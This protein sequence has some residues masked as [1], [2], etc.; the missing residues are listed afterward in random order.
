[1][2]PKSV[3]NRPDLKAVQLKRTCHAMDNAFAEA[4]VTGYKNLLAELELP[5]KDDR[6][7][8]A[9]AIKS[10][11]DTIITFNKKDFPARNLKLYGIDCKDPDEFI[12]P[13]LKSNLS[14]VLV[15]FERLV[16]A[17][18]NPP[19]S[20]EQVLNTLENCGLKESIIVIRTVAMAL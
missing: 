10:G 14:R 16:N 20:K 9:I 13:L 8:L 7:V 5:D 17:L 19:Q 4:N 15:A 2:D 12:G 3:K 1:M 11:A 6:H 18:K